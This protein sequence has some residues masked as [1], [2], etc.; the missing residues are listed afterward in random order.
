MKLSLSS[1]KKFL[2]EINMIGQLEHFT[3]DFKMEKI[4]VPSISETKFEAHQSL[5]CID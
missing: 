5:A 3:G 1:I 2:M 4:F